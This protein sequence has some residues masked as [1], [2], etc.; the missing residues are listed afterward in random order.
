MKLALK[1]NTTCVE[2]Q[3]N[4]LKSMKGNILKDLDEVMKNMP[5]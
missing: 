2:T 1:C 4:L 3:I 5:K